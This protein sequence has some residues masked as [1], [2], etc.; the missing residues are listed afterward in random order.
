M[1]ISIFEIKDREVIA[2]RKQLATRLLDCECVQ[3]HFNYKRMFISMWMSNKWFKTTSEV[4]TVLNHLSIISNHCTW[5]IY[6]HGYIFLKNIACK[7]GYNISVSLSHYELYLNL[8]F[9]NFAWHFQ[10][11][12]HLYK[13]SYEHLFKVNTEVLKL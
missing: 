1:S 7:L 13:S 9:F 4:I 3:K 12:T 11:Y 2:L 6:F 5:V 10:N 8:R